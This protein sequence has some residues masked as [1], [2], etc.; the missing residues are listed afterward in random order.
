[1]T[2]S[3]NCIFLTAVLTAAA[4]GI[5]GTAAETTTPPPAEER[6]ALEARY[7]SPPAVVTAGMAKAGEGYFAGDARRI[8][9]QAVPPGRPFYEIFVQD[10]SANAPRPSVP[11]RVSPGRGRTTCSWFSPDG[12]RL[13]FASSHLD[14]DA[15]ATESAA[16]KQ[17][18]EDARAGR[19]RRYQW[20][21]DPWM[22]LFTSRLDGSDLVRL[23]TEKGYDAECSFSPDGSQVVFVSDRDGDPDI[24]LM[25][26]DGSNVRQLTNEPGYDGGPFF[27][28]DGRWIAYRTDRI[29]KDMLQ[30]HAMRADGSGDVAITSGKAVHWAPFWHPTRPWLI[31]TG[32]DHSDPTARPNY[33]L[34]IAA[35]EITPE[36]SFAAGSPLRLTDHP[37]ADVLP[38]FSPDGSLLM[39][40]ASRGGD[41]G[42]RNAASQLWVSRFDA[43][44]V[45]ADIPAATKG[46]VP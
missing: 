17:A 42:G 7:L 13:L 1:M 11:T 6:S 33:D 3:C 36:G 29:E 37:G 20:D 24:Y 45:A 31:W 30:I 4:A 28:P 12:T 32:A 5:R 46:P 26:A 18:E 38:A 39:W 8:C 16:A 21:F 2:R 43:D 19:R 15:A 44:A 34:W 9:Y 41:S 23:T 40:T 27:S 25:D 10:F 14:P 22:D 35:W